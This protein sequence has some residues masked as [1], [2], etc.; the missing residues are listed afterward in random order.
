LPSAGCQRLD[1]EHAA[2]LAI[3]GHRGPLRSV[4][5]HKGLAGEFGCDTVVTPKASVKASLLGHGAAWP[6]PHRR[7]S[8]I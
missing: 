8:L 7:P 2:S 1:P 6:W 3:S 5:V 4:P